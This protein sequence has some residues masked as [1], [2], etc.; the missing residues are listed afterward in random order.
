MEKKIFDVIIIGS[1]IGGLASASILS[2]VYHKRVLVLERH[3]KLGGYT[4]TFKRKAK[5][6][7][8]V[9]V[10]YVGDMQPQSPIR[11]YFDYI[12]GGQ[13][14]WNKMPSPYD[15]FI[16]P[17]ITF[18]AKVGKENL[19]NDL[20]TQ[21]PT[22]K[23]SLKQYF[24]DIEKAAGWYSKYLISN[25]VPKMV[26]PLTNIF[27]GSGKAFALQTTKNYLDNHFRD[28]WLKGI[29]VSQWG[30]YGLPPALSAFC[31]HAMIVNHYINGGWYPVGGASKIAETISAVV[32]NAG[33]QFLKSHQVDEIIIHKN[34]AIGVR[35]TAGQKEKRQEE[36]FTDKIISDVG[37]YNTFINL[38][39]SKYLIPF[40]EDITNFPKCTSNVSL[41]IGL[42]GDPH[43]SWV[44][45]ENYWIYNSFDH[46]KIFHSRNELLDGK[47]SHAFVS[48]PSLKD[49][50]KEHHTAE[51][52][53]FTGY[54]AFKQWANQP[55]KNR[56]AD[57]NALKERISKALIDFVHASLPNFKPLIEYYELGTPLTNEH[58]TGH[59]RGCS[60]GLPGIPE[61]FQKQWLRPKTLIKNLY[62][63][64][65]DTA[66]HGVVPC[67]MSGILSATLAMGRPQD[68]MK[69]TKVAK[70]F[71][72]S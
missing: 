13:L 54:G 27:T 67:M 19:L 36:F 70:R 32:E 39:P 4:H 61:R 14:H 72:N 69:I 28:K 53:A 57:Y 66:T 9:G 51:I 52:I 33:G 40:R 59:H 34:K 42:N 38:V 60:Y 62:L 22:E 47:A 21:F 18:E 7:W 49:P 1:G 50:E 23:D 8:D 5:Y 71:S 12:S 64:G 48:F 29:L 44:N 30:D 20:M 16:Y 65:A 11:R 3:S 46:N 35:V 68:M 55:V 26:K 6:Q 41:F 25:S 2:Q 45:G 17:D 15:V 31:I 24:K 43:L 58:Y 37:A 56:H 63:T 10:H